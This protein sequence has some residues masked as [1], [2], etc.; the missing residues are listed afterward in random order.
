VLGLSFKPQTDDIRDSVGVDFAKFLV[1]KGA[2]VK[3]FDPIAM[4]KAKE[5]LSGVEFCPDLW[6]A[7]ENADAIVIATEWN[8]FR[9]MNLNRLKDR[10][11]G[12]LIV[13]L[14]NIYEPDAMRDLGFVHVGVGRGTPPRAKA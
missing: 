6:S 8:E 13:D 4:D 7:V 1:E 11:R 5:T 3:A 2:M 14:K 9:T 12:N 10:M